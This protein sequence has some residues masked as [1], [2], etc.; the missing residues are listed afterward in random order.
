MKRLHILAVGLGLIALSHNA[1]AILIEGSVSY[2]DGSTF[3]FAVDIDDS[4]TW[5][6]ASNIFLPSST[7]V[8]SWSTD[9][10]FQGT[11]YN[12]IGRF[13]FNESPSDTGTVYGD[14]TLDTWAYYLP[15]PADSPSVWTIELD[16]SF[17]AQDTLTQPYLTQARSSD[18]SVTTTSVPEPAS[19]ALM[20]LGLVGLGFSRRRKANVSTA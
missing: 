10:F 13:D 5:S 3:N 2:E 19:F 8:N 17:L 9:L 15:S 4:Y 16:S 20:G 14:S 1:N 12:D 18:F 11:H 6:E 7:N